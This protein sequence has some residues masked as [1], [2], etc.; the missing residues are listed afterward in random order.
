MLYPRIIPSLLLSENRLVKTI[1]FGAETYIGDPINAVR[2]FNEKEADELALMDIKASRNGV[3]NYNLLSRIAR[4]AF[5]PLS[6]GGGIQNVEEVKRL[7]GLGYEKIILNSATKSNPELITATAA[8]CGSQ[9]TVVCVDYSRDLFGKPKIFDHLAKKRTSQDLFSYL[10]KVQNL[11][12]GEVILHDRDREGTYLGLDKNIIT[13][14][15][16]KINIP[17]VPLGG[18]SSIEEIWDLLGETSV[19]AFAAGSIFVYHGPRKAVLITYPKN[20]RGNRLS[21][22]R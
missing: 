4:E 10:I 6:Y 2:I 14:A 13:Q 5:M 18:A 1:K 8:L 11:G 19:Q 16:S 3:I 17:I 7:L 9:S 22:E 12:A 15:A 20:Q 21:H